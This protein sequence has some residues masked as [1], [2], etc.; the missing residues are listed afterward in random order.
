MNKFKSCLNY[1]NFEQIEQ[2]MCPNEAYNAF[3]A[4]YKSAFEDSFPL[5]NKSVN[6]KT[7]KREPWFTT[8]LLIY[9]K[10][11]RKLKNY[12]NLHKENMDNIKTSYR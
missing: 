10:K 11:R 4:L 9:S 1:I 6:Y 2:I 3:M 7:I 12:N 5:R 8:G